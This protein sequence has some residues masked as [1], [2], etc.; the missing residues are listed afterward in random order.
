MP[1]PVIAGTV[2]V[3][4]GGTITGGSTW[5]NN[6]HIRRADLLAPEIGDIEGARDAFIVF[7]QDAVF[8]SVPA[9]TTLATINFTPLDGTSGAISYAVGLVGDGGANAAAAQTAEV[10]TIRTAQRGRQNRGRV[11]LP[12][13]VEEDWDNLGHI[14]ATA[15]ARV[16]AASALL[17]A[18][19]DGQGW[20]IG[21]GSYGPYLNPITHVLEVG[22]PHFTPQTSLTMDNLSDVQR[23]RKG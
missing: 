18:T 7:Y 1:L 10:I 19:L 15:I 21:V 14:A 6:W 2:R 4:L 22:T 12:A 8:H 5:S 11:Y 16:A 3:S 13:F 17:V 20:E 9:G 23:S